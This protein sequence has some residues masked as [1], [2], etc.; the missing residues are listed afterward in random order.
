MLY[1]VEHLRLYLGEDGGHQA[2]HHGHD[3]IAVRE[4][5]LQVKLRE[6][7]L[8]VRPQVLSKYQIGMLPCAG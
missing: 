3:D 7:R 2:L 1:I 5:Q 4:G 8:P 6:L